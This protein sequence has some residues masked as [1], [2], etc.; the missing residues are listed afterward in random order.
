[1]VIYNCDICNYTTIR[2]NQYQR[3][4]NTKK[5]NRNMILSGEECSLND[6]QKVLLKCPFC[7]DTFNT[8]TMFAQ[9][10]HDNHLMELNSVNPQNKNICFENNINELKTVTQSNTIVTQNEPTKNYVCEFCNKDF[11]HSNSYYRHL[12]HYCKNKKENNISVND[13]K[14]FMYT[15]VD[16]LIE[17]T[18]NCNNKILEEKDKSKYE[19]LAEKERSN[20]LFMKVLEK[21]NNGGNIINQNNTLNNSNYVLQFFNYSE[22]DSMDYIKDQFKLTREEFIKASLTSGYRGAL[23][24]KAENIIIKPYLKT[25][26]KRPMHTVDSSRKKALYK[27]EVHTKW[28]FHPKT[29]LDHCFE[30]FHKSALEHQDQTIKENPNWVIES[31]DDSLYKQTYFIPTEIKTKESIYKEVQNHIYKETKV[32]R[33]QILNNYS[34]NL[35]E[36][37]DEILKD[38]KDIISY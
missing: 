21:N 4:L 3:H 32:N 22:A 19:L 11:K 13:Y 8:N 36:I 37:E 34:E 15:M 27:D 17:H 7:N 14:D 6:G 29:T 18:N 38:N 35:L 33:K 31:N 23:L 2:K 16:K 26:D 25:Q 1:M 5:H 30:T 20:N 10:L 12:K 9:H 28:T 24:E